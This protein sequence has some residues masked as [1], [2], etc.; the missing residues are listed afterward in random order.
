MASSGPDRLVAYSRERQEYLA[1]DCCGSTP[2]RVWAWSGSLRQAKNMIRVYPAS[3][4]FDLYLD[5]EEKFGRPVD[6]T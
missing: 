2:S 1:Y 5:G 6:V 3:S 4:N